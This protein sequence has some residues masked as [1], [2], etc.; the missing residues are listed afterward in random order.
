MQPLTPQS[1][2][3]DHAVRFAGIARLYG[4]RALDAFSQARVAVVGIG[5]VGSWAAEALARSG[6]GH[7]TLIDMD[8]ICISNTNRQIH[9][10]TSTIGQQKADAM[11][12]RLL[13][14]NPSC[15]VS[16][17]LLFITEKNVGAELTGFDY[18]IDAIDS[19]KHKCALL[20]HCQSNTIRVVTAG[21]AGGQ[22]DPTLIQYAD[23]SRTF[24]DPL[25][26]KVRKNLRQH[27]GFPSDPQRRFGIE[28]VFSAEQPVFPTPEGEICKTRT[29]VA[30]SLRLDCAAGYGSATT[31]TATFGFVAVSRVLRRLADQAND[32]A[33]RRNACNNGSV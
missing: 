31:V 24:H 15:E 27:Y 18:V 13:Q 2:N 17:R 33:L 12:K 8:D 30:D 22:S 23:L 29:V 20:H 4:G 5:G 21:A 1:M 3:P 14:I 19:V 32:L 25:L 6:I 9:T 28:A 10:L 16:S 26:S 7:I 11:C